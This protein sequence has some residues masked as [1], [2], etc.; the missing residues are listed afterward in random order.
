L[1]L[2]KDEFACGAGNNMATVGNEQ[3]MHLSVRHE[4]EGDSK[5]H[6]DDV[7]MLSQWASE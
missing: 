1:N 2:Q 7:A 3:E 5:W 6:H 4:E